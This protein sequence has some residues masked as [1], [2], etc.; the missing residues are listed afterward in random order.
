MS[1]LDR[2]ARAIFDAMPH[3]HPTGHEPDWTIQPEHLKDV[4][5]RKAGAQQT[6]TRP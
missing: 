5:R 1:D 6:E 3:R 2:R 4:F